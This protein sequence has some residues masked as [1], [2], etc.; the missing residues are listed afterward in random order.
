MDIDKYIKENKFNYKTSYEY[1]QSI[2]KMQL[3]GV[4][5]A[6]AFLIFGMSVE[7][8]SVETLQITF[9]SFYILLILVFIFIRLARKTY[10][11]EKFEEVVI[12]DT[13]RLK[14]LCS[15]EEYLEKLAYKTNLKKRLNKAKQN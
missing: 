8:P 10:N 5:I 15:Y 4:L 14:Y 7:H 12:D 9:Y 13:L 6:T 11:L 1:S 2:D 3:M